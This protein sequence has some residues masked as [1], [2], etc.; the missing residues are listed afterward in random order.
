VSGNHSHGSAEQ[1]DLLFSPLPTNPPMALV[2]EPGLGSLIH[3]LSPPTL[4][5]LD[6][7]SRA[8]RISRLTPL[9]GSVSGTG[10]SLPTLPIR[11]ACRVPG[12]AAAPRGELFPE[13]RGVSAG[14]FLSGAGA[15]SASSTSPCWDTAEGRNK[16]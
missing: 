7:F 10:A 5:W 15:I 12:S 2:V 9:P 4:G 1:L 16:P 8:T 11:L 13:G 6:T 14:G 3:P